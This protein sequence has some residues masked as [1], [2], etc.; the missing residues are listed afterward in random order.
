[1]WAEVFER[2]A[3]M[4]R[5]MVETLEELARK[6]GGTAEGDRPLPHA[7]REHDARRLARAYANPEGVM[8]TLDELARV[9]GETEEGDRPLPH[10]SQAPDARRLARAY[11][12][13]KGEDTEISIA[14]AMREHTAVT[15]Q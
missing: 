9:A 14:A 3:T 7:S 1:M 8:E 2:L 15:G 10:A 5:K 13:P 4:I 11:P 12:N 6:A